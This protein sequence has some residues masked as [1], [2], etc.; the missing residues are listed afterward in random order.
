MRA[1]EKPELQ[2]GRGLSTPE[3]DI[4]REAKLNINELQW[5]RG[6]STPEVLNDRFAKIPKASLQWG[7]GL[8]TP[9]VP[10]NS[11]DACSSRW[12][13]WGRGLSTPEVRPVRHARIRR[14][15]FNGAGVFRP[16]KYQPAATRRPFGRRLQWGRGL[17]TPEVTDSFG[18][19]TPLGSLQWGRGLS[20]PEVP[21]SNPGLIRS[22]RLQWGRG[23]STPEVPRFKCPELCRQDASM[24]PGSFDP[25]SK[26][27]T[28]SASRS[29]GGFNGAGVFRPRKCRR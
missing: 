16:R 25:G 21:L 24:G 19:P 20:T 1:R 29:A 4:I 26:N 17:S 8:S 12:L 10:G 14:L 27:V 11:G 7:R 2:W 18:M 3:V 9:E 13:Q 5:G 6:L 15:C 23:L 28:P 22:L